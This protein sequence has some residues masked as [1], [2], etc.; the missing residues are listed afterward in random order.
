[1]AFEELVRYDAT[2]EVTAN[3]INSDI[4]AF[5]H[6]CVYDPSGELGR[7]K[8]RPEVQLQIESKLNEKSGG[9]YVH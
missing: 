5:I 6:S 8:S 2:I 4:Q 1:M 3:L 9:M 7:W